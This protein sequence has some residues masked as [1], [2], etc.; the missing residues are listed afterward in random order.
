MHLAVE[1][2]PTLCVERRRL[3]G[4]S[5]ERIRDLLGAMAALYVPTSGRILP[6]WKPGGPE[7]RHRDERSDQTVWSAT[8]PVESPVPHTVAHAV[9]RAEVRPRA[10]LWS[11]VVVRIEYSPAPGPL[12]WLAART[13]L[14]WR[15]S[16]GLA[17]LVRAMGRCTAP[18]WARKAL[19]GASGRDAPAPRARALRPAS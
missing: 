5:A 4:V 14:R 7:Y 18:A 16:A 11:E 12:A 13:V 15:L 8:A 19:A 17:D 9:F 2:R 1:H 10:P 3:V 6:R